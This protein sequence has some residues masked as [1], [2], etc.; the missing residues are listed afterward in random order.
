MCEVGVW[1]NFEELEEELTLDELFIL[2]ETT[3]ERQMRLLKTVSAALGASTEEE[4][5]G[6]DPKNP[7]YEYQQ[8]E[9][10]GEGGSVLFG[11]RTKEV[12][13]GEE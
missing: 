7:N 4:E 10:I 12:T 8:Q 9:I 5:E 11:Y 13:P 6:F 3:T 2:Y 1:K